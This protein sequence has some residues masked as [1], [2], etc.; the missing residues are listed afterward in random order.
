MKIIR[1]KGLRAKVF[2]RDGGICAR[3]QRYDPKWEHDHEQPL[4]MGGRDDL[5]N[6]ITL[7]R[8]CHR[9]KTSGEAPVR[10]KTDRLRLRHELTQKRKQIVRTA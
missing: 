4:S 7:C 6:S 8:D 5:D 1:N 2:D 3:C 10:A 9:R